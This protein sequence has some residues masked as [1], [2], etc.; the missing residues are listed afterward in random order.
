MIGGNT[1]VHPAPPHH[2][3]PLGDL[4]AHEPH[5]DPLSTPLARA[6]TDALVATMAPPGPAGRRWIVALLVVIGWGGL[7][8]A[9]QLYKGLA[10]TAM[11]D[12]FS[13]GVYIIDFVFFIGI[14]M[15][16]TLISAML[17]LTGASWRHPITRLAE[18]VTILALLIAA[19]MIAI[20][21]GRPDRAWYPLVYGRLQSPILWDVLSLNTYLA[22][23]VLYFYV[24]L[25][26][27][28]A[29]LA[30]RP[31]FGTFRRT[32][33]RKLS[34]GWT[35]TPRQ[36]ALLDRALSAQSII[37][38]PVAV[39][40]HTVTS[41]IFGMTLRPGWHSTII[42][43]DFVAG[44]LYSGV[45]AVITAIAAFRHFLRLE[46]F[47]TVDPFRKLSLLLL[48][49]CVVYGYFVINEYMGAVYA[50]EHSER[51]L[52]FN[53]LHGTYSPE[54]WSM[55]GIGLVLPF[56]LLLTP[57]TR[58][59]AGVVTASVLV[60]IGMWLKRF[61]IIIPTLASPYM[62]PV[63][64][65]WEPPKYVPSL[66]EWS[67]SAAGVA[68]FCL[69]FTLL[70]KAVPIVSI[71][72]TAGDPDPGVAPAEQA[73]ARPRPHDGSLVPVPEVAL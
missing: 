65:R 2:G 72:E 55:V 23:S 41:W 48:V 47:I 63:A 56:I 62:P 40:I 58:T 44:A 25:I 27:D 61:V 5:V 42:G 34:L 28:L 16:G 38:I 71:W 13:W 66:V 19:P 64:T 53:V 46:R 9:W 50:H 22:G 26:P 7:C 73:T 51:A 20:D 37:I 11:T 21:M 31:E 39:S 60:N 30:G 33:Y 52:L 45:A 70:A 10:V 15:A 43:P 6:R 12:F 29:L 54:F 68:M 57:W 4:V 69:L 32:V 18:G 3:E 59:V 1:P 36:H 14:S 8:Y 35:G 67:I 49:L 24:P 17:R